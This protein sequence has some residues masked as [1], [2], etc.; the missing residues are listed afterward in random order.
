MNKIITLILILIF[1]TSCSSEV[2]R[3]H[4]NQAGVDP[5]FNP[6]IQNYSDILNL[7]N[8]KYKYIYDQRIKK[9]SVNFANL[10][11]STIGRCH[12]LLNGEFEIEIDKEYWYRAGFLSRQFLIYHELEHCIRF[13]LHTHEDLYKQNVWQYIEHLAQL[14]GLIPKKGYFKDG[15]PNSIMHPSDAGEWCHYEHYDSYIKEMIDYKDDKL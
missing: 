4:P 8:K 2:V 12:W 13:R 9:L 3:V 1:L 10:N 7:K 14:M 11:G 6:Y 15:C 5:L